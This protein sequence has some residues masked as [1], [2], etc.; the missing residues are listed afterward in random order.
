[1]QPADVR[2]L[3]DDLA[4]A[5]LTIHSGDRFG[6]NGLVGAVF[7][8]QDGATTYIDNFLLSCRVF[9]R[10]I[11]QACLAAVLEHAR[12]AGATAVIGSYRPTAK[13]GNFRDFYPSN[14]FHSLSEQ[15]D[16]AIY[17][18]DLAEFPGV[19]DHISLTEEL[20]PWVENAS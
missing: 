11:E 3:A 16:V 13:N 1:L 17:R 6:D 15:D 7:T 4:A 14:G 2:A 18:H 12:S 19:P 8:H 9:A 10:G 20:A 5:V